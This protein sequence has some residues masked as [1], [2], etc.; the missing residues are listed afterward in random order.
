MVS[1]FFLSIRLPPSSTRTD[2]LFPYAT[3]F[4]SCGVSA[5]LIGIDD[6]AQRPQPHAFAK[7]IGVFLLLGKRLQDHAQ[8][9]T[10]NKMSGQASLGS[11][12]KRPLGNIEWSR[13]KNIATHHSGLIGGSTQFPGQPG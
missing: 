13:T 4:R 12:L 5:S 2:T 7:L 3:L 1:L 6:A 9:C 10:G 11:Q 8:I